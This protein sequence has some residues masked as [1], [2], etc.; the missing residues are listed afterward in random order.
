MRLV[1][2][3]TAPLVRI[4][5]HSREDT[6]SEE[7]RTSLP[8]HAR[9]GFAVLIWTFGTLLRCAWC[10]T[11]SQLND[12]LSSRSTWRCTEIRVDSGSQSGATRLC[13]CQTRRP[14]V[15]SS[16]C[17]QLRHPHAQCRT[18][19]GASLCASQRWTTPS[20]EKNYT[21]I[22]ISHRLSAD[23]RVLYL[24]CSVSLCCLTCP[25]SRVSCPGFQTVTKRFPF[26]CGNGSKSAWITR[27]W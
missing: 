11:P 2:F 26:Y 9:D 10:V 14:N 24:V 19:S 12:D 8:R 6:P 13:R 17:R 25:L 27:V 16:T 3:C 7:L 22:I 4:A 18:W 21:T 20:L 5:A 23:S 1:P 15:R